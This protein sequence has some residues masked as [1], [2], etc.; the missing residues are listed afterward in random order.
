MVEKETIFSSSVKYIGI[1]SFKDFY[2]FCY[3]WLTEE[4]DL[5]I[6][7]DKYKERLKGDSKE[8]E[9]K[10]TGSKKLTDYFKFEMEVKFHV[11]DLTEV[12]MVKGNTKFKTNKGEVKVSIKGILIRDWQGKFERS[13]Y[14]KFLREIYDR[15]VIPSRIE[16]LEDKIIGDCDEFLS[17]AK[18]YLALEGKR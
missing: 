12:E 4:T 7:E 3:E 14:R 6:S 15:W 13:A 1:F 18:A 16:Q 9:I 5:D 2:K 8:I 17:Q 11:L 10:W